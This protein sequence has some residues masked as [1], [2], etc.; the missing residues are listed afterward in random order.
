MEVSFDNIP[1]LLFAQL[2]EKFGKVVSN[3]AIIVCKVFRPELRDFPSRDVAVHP[4]QE[5][6]IISHLRRE[7]IKQ[8]GC[9]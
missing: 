9:F 2:P 5:S 8:A 1:V 6:R 4:V 3:K 7:M